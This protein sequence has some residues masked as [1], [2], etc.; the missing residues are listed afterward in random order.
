M[1]ISRTKWDDYGEAHHLNVAS[2]HWCKGFWAD[3][4][5]PHIVRTDFGATR[6]PSVHPFYLVRAK[7]VDLP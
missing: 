6:Q 2:G 4:V 5:Y 1:K 3:E 7:S